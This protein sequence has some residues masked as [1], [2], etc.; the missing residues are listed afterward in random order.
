MENAQVA[1]IFEEIAD[2]IELQ[3]GNE[4]RVR[5]YRSAAQT[6]RDLSRRLEDMVE[7]DEDLTELPDVGESTA[8]KIE[9]IIE[10]GTCRRLEEQR[11]RIPA[12][13]SELMDIEGLGPRRTMLVYRELGVE[14]LDGLREA[15][16]RQKVR[17]LEGMGP[18]TEEK[19]LAGIERLE[20]TAGRILCKAAAD[21]A[22]SLGRH[23]D[24]I[25][26]I[27]RWEMAGSFRRRRETVGDLDVVIEASDRGRATAKILEYGGVAETLARGREKVTVRL[28]DGLNVDLRFFDPDEFGSALLYFTGSKAHNIKLRKRAQSRGWK[29][30]EYGLMKGDQRLAGRDEV[31]VYN[32]LDL[33]WVPPEIREDRGEVEAAEKDALPD[34]IELDDVRG[35]LQSHTSAT[36]GS[37]SI[38]EMAEAAHERGY[39][40]FAITDHSKRV[41]MAGGLDEDALR[42]HA[43]E[44]RAVAE[45]Y[46]DMWLLAGV[47][48]DILKDGTLDIDEG[49]LAELDWVVAS[50][51]YDMDQDERTM[52]DRLVA[53]IS[54]GVVHA[55]GHPF[56][57]L[58][59]KRD[60]VALDFDRVLEA[61][62]KYNV[63]LEIN[64]QPERLDL[65][66][67]YCKRAV[68]AGVGFTLGTD[69][70][71]P[72]DLDLM[73]FAVNV[74]RRGWVGKGD[75][76]NTRTLRQF[77]KWLDTVQE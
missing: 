35:D 55:V 34:L 66:D 33:A 50:I 3:E 51:H 28:D 32:R 56:N 27:T 30:N 23:L 14:D 65:P 21:H 68:E 72:S 73:P 13:L 45:D 61:C 39:D 77:E 57:R 70:H 9:E 7:G 49:V 19:I 52:T 12:G 2:L 69:A 44:I 59:G 29:L 42:R 8:E 54:S 20:K 5:S 10:T 1:D 76:L 75:V 71:K 4:F 40:Y 37:A 46:G 17:E 47:E 62:A 26:A 74:A 18:K 63:H 36:D 24:S 48:V 31:S 15:C 25:D 67:S 58:I 22:T 16:E 38:E 64:A 53:A 43:D 60:G 41:T 11:D 6:V